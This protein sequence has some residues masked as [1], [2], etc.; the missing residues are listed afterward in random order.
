MISEASETLKYIQEG[1][2][3]LCNF[4]IELL[5]SAKSWNGN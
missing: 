3:N 5:P 1:S 4:I 2:Q